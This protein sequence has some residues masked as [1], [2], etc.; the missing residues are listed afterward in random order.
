MSKQALSFSQ[1][2]GI[3]DWKPRCEL[4]LQVAM[5]AQQ[6]FDELKKGTDI[7]GIQPPALAKFLGQ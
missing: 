6:F 5:T 4:N 3:E 1:T 7:V 2:S